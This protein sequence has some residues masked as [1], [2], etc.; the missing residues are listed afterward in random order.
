MARDGAINSSACRN[1]IAAG[2][3]HSG[4]GRRQLRKAPGT[5]LVDAALVC[6]KVA[7]KHG[8]ERAAEQRPRQLARANE[9]EAIGGRSEAP[10][11]SQS[12]AGS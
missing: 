3:L 4:R 12:R 7:S 5:P 9:R 6:G 11:L 1:V 10:G 2:T 8:R